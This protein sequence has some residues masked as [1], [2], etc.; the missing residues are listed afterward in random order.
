MFLLFIRSLNSS[1]SGVQATAELCSEALGSNYSDPCSQSKTGSPAAMSFVLA[2]CWH[3]LRIASRCSKAP[4]VIRPKGGGLFFLPCFAP[5]KHLFMLLSVTT[6]L[7]D[8][9]YTEAFL[10]SCICI[11]PGGMKSACRNRKKGLVTIARHVARISPISSHPQLLP[12]SCETC[13]HNALRMH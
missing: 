1:F 8:S 6:V 4:T 3:K 7:C 2:G 11:S 5:F 12:R 9:V 10:L 13:W